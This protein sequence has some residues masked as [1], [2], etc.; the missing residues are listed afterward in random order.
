MALGLVDALSNL[1]TAAVLPRMLHSAARGDWQDV[2][3]AAPSQPQSSAPPGWQLMALTITCYEPEER[4]RP[5]DF[6]GSAG[7]FL[8]SD[9][10]RALVRPDGVCAPMPAPPPAAI[11]G[12]LGTS[13][14]PVLFINGAADPKDPPENVAGARR[15]YP[16]GLAL[17]VPNQAHDYNVDPTRRAVLFAAFVET[18]SA[19]DLPSACLRDQWVPPFDLG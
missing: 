11:H 10:M 15:A 8:A 18:A 9:D 2:L 7:S 19:G 14:I 6:P 1:R 16:N 17:T 4:M 13:P 3:A 5:G 12:P